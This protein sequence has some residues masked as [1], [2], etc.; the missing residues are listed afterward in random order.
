V[1]TRD[2]RGVVSRLARAISISNGT[3]VGAKIFTTSD[4]F[5]LDVFRV[6]DASGGPFGDGGRIERLRQTIIK[7]LAGEIRPR[8]V[9]AKRPPGRRAA[10]FKTRPRVNFDNGAATVSTVGVGGN[11]IARVL[12]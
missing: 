12:P 6:Q 9:L 11:A 10:A 3:I 1:S 4:G 2:E 8:D 7:N 5:A